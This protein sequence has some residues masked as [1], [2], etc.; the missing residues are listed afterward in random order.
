MNPTNA[1]PS[2]PWRC[3]SVQAEYYFDFFMKFASKPADIVNGAATIRDLFE[4][5][6]L[7]QDELCLIWELG[8]LDKGTRV[9]LIYSQNWK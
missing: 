1:D 7:S 8:D 5:S 6:K 4:K 3:S 2:D 9:L